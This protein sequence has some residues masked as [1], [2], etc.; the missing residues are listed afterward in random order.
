MTEGDADLSPPLPPQDF[1]AVLFDMDGTILSSIQAA[2]RVWAAWARSHG[3]DVGLVLSTMHGVRAVET[4]RRL[5]LP[6]IDPVSEAERVTLAEMEDVEGIE[7]LG[8]AA[9]L[10]GGLPRDRWAIVTSAPRVLALR[11]L[12]AAGLPVPDVLVSADDVEHGKPAPDCF[13]LAA[14]RLGQPAGACLVFEDT[15]AGVQ[16]ADAAGMASIVITATHATPIETQSATIVDY[17]ALR[18][19]QQADGLLRLRPVD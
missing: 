8:G 1:G 6:D 12:A 16:A 10:L 14:E 5:G 3:L 19:V 15:V 18:I 17:G 9:D 2:E 11:R 7:A 4:I 13:L